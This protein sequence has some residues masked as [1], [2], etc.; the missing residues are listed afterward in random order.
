MISF[1]AI[2][3]GCIQGVASRNSKIRKNNLKNTQ[4]LHKGQYNITAHP[5]MQQ[6]SVYSEVYKKAVKNCQIYCQ[7]VTSNDRL[8]I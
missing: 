7:I 2:A 1:F 4:M 8:A 5:P 6:Y 3:A